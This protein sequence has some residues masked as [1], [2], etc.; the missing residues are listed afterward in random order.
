MNQDLSR[1]KKLTKVFSGKDICILTGSQDFSKKQLEMKIYE[2]GG[3]IVQ[4]PGKLLTI[5]NRP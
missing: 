2:N 3:N 5:Q 4:N 1:V